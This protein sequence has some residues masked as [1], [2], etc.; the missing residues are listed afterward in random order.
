M[1]LEQVRKGGSPPLL[2]ERGQAA[3][4]DLFYFVIRQ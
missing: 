1:K 4:P 2:G 3:L